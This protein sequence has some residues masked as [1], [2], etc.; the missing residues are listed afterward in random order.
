MM[1]GAVGRRYAKALFALAKESAALQ[2]AADQ[3]NRVAALASDPDIGPVLRSPLLSAV[4]RTEI[5]AMLARELQLSDLLT[6]FVLLLA[7]QQRLGALPAIATRFQALLDDELGRVRVAVSAARALDAK[8]E[9]ELVATF[10]K[11]TG[12]QVIHT[13][14]LDPDLL[15]GIVVEAEGKVYDGSVRT[16]FDRLEKELGGSAAL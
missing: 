5:A 6:R 1:S 2:P 9:A 14:T 4:R 8:Q 7:D 15:G 16:Q 12:K 11:L 10:A 13:V 3:L